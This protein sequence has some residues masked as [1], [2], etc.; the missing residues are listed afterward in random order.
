MEE[1]LRRK[2]L[3]RKSGVREKPGKQ[4]QQGEKEAW[5]AE[6][7]HAR[8]AREAI[9]GDQHKREREELNYKRDWVVYEENRN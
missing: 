6:A 5:E 7:Q 1:R 4:K 2:D 3:L 8:E 9:R